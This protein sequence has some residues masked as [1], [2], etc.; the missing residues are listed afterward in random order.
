MASLFA[1]ICAILPL[2][3]VSISSNTIVGMCSAR[4]VIFLTASMKRDIS[5]PLITLA[6]GLSGSPGFAL[7]RKRTLSNDATDGDFANVSI[8]GHSANSTTNFVFFMPRSVSSFITSEARRA[9]HFLRRSDT[10]RHS[11][12]NFPTISARCAVSSARRSS[13]WVILSK[14][15]TASS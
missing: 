14:R 11:L 7:I 5:P 4:A 10:A 12:Y 6:S 2:I 15:S 3:P 1:T 13:E 8:V 9:A